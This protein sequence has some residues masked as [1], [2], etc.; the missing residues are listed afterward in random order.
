MQ[1]ILKQLSAHLND[2][3][4]DVPWVLIEMNTVHKIAKAWLYLNKETVC[5]SSMIVHTLATNNFMYSLGD[6]GDN[7]D[8]AFFVFERT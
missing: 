8:F 5:H 4:L 3:S 1:E 2:L 7:S 6:L